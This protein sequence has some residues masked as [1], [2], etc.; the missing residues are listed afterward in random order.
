MLDGTP[1]IAPSNT[2]KLARL[3]WLIV[4]ARRAVHDLRSMRTKEG[5]PHNVYM[6]LDDSLG[7]A[8]ELSLIRARREGKVGSSVPMDTSGL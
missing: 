5:S 2:K 7:T 4:R 8:D 6:T 3:T 1:T